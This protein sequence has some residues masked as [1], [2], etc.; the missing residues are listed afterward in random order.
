MIGAAYDCLS[1][2]N[3]SSVWGSNLSDNIRGK[4]GSVPAN[5]A[6]KWFLKFLIVAFAIFL[7]RHAVVI[8]N[9]EHY[10][11]LAMMYKLGAR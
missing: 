9:A 3:V 5:K 2:F 7:L 1:R 11:V 4:F 8:I 6:M 10:K